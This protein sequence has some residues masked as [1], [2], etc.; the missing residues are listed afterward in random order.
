[1]RPCIHKC[2][3]EMLYELSHLN[4]YAGSYCRAHHFSAFA[5]TVPMHIKPVLPIH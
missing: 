4:T 1:M 5:H 3:N 2:V